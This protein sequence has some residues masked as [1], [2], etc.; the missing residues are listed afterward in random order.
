[1]ARSHRA[2]CTATSTKLPEV[3]YAVVVQNTGEQPVGEAQGRNERSLQNLGGGA[4]R[5]G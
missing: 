2:L 1:M 3:W 5:R 4:R